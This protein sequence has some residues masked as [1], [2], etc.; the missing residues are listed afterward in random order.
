MLT[1]T[2]KSGPL[3]TDD[4]DGSAGV[5]GDGHGQVVRCRDCRNN[6]YIEVTTMAKEARP[7]RRLEEIDRAPAKVP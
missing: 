5:K 3:S 4:Q 7:R 1:R 2:R 6:I